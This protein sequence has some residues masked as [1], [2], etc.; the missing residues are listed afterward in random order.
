L[1]QI[2]WEYHYKIYKI[3]KDILENYDGEKILN[4][5]QKDSLTVLVFCLVSGMGIQGYIA[6]KP[7][8]YKR[9]FEE[10]KKIFFNK[11][12]ECH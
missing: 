2:F 9:Y 4:D 5:V 3:I 7:F 6:K 8:D 1:Q 10:F 11:S 12:T